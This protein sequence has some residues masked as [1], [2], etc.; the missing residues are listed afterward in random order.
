[1]GFLIGLAP[2]FGLGFTLHF[3]FA[4]LEVMLGPFILM[5]GD[6]DSMTHGEDE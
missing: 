1:M 4:V 2:A 3:E 5:L 6:V